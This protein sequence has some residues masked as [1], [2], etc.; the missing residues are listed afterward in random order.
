MTAKTG[1]RTCS[2]CGMFYPSNA[3]EL[4]QNLSDMLD[5]AAPGP[6]EGTVLGIIS[7]HAGY[8]YSGPTASFAYTLLRGKKYDTVVIVSPS[9]REYFDG[10][11][12]FPG[13]AYRTPLGVVLVDR[14]LRKE[15]LQQSAAIRSSNA[16]HGDEHA[17]EV[18]LPFLQHVL[19]DFSFLPV[20][21]GD[22]K[23]HY[24][25]ALGEA[26]GKVLRGK[27]ALIVASTD[28]SHY[29]PADLANRLDAVAIEDVGKF[30]YEK[31]MVDLEQ[32]RTEACGGGPVVAVMLALRTLGAR[33]MAVLHHCNSGDVTGDLSQVVGYLAAVAYA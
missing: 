17:V 19:G 3:A 28:L 12:V 31:L 5:A 7:P 14:D 16:G 30:D 13:D 33:K 23:R 18:H 29:Y 11:S 15:L 4:R 10:I 27:R 32:N 25:F 26:L 2:V 8:V 20:V 6:M 1:E 22:Q 9:H 21:M 24:C